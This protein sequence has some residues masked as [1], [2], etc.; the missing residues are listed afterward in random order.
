[1]RRGGFTLIELVVALALFTVLAMLL[2]E[3]LRIATRTAR[4]VD[5]R[6][7]RAHELQV[8]LQFLAREL[9]RAQALKGESGR[10]TFSAG[11][12]AFVIEAGQGSLRLSHEG[13]A[14]V[15]A[16]GLGEVR[17]AY[18][19]RDVWQDAWDE[20]DVPRLVR[21]RLVPG[22]ELVAAP[23]LGMSRRDR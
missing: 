18:L 10:M 14:T 6:A 1:M 8:A 13:R 12:R 11:T 2:G 16:Q 15:L 23:M 9:E 3:A 7:V 22:G 19:G 4:A 17:F 5:E 20:R 21:V